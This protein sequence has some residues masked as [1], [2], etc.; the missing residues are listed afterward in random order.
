MIEGNKNVEKEYGQDENKNS[1][2]NFQLI[3]RTV[4]LNWYWFILS[5]II[6]VGLAA[7][8]L[9]YTTPTYQTVAKLLIK[10]QEDNKKSGIKYSSNLGIISN[11]EGIDNEIEILGSRS[12]D[13]SP[14]G[15]F[16]LFV[17]RSGIQGSSG[18]ICQFEPCF[19]IL[20]YARCT[21]TDNL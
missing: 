12:D 13:R 17:G 16:T 20:G 1:F 15:G 4:I 6:C 19:R 9:R 14:P 18:Q 2:I 21:R 3:Y 7:I 11:S 10:D 5:V 8:Y